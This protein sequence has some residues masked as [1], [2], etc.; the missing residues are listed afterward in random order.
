MLFRIFLLLTF[1]F[2]GVSIAAWWNSPYLIERV[3]RSE[4]AAN[5]F[6]VPSFVMDRP[7]S[8][9]IE[10]DS[11][12]LVSQDMEIELS[13]VVIKPFDTG[14]PHISVAAKRARIESI[15]RQ[16]DSETSPDWQSL[17]ESINTS[18]GLLPRY[19]AVEQLQ[20]C[21]EE[22]LA[23]TLR[24]NR[25]DTLIDA[26]FHIPDQN[27]FAAFL[28]SRQKSSIS[29]TGYS[30]H[31]FM[32]QVEFVTGEEE[33]MIHGD[34]RYLSQTGPLNIDGE[35][36]LNYQ[37]EME[38]FSATLKGAIPLDG[39]VSIEAIKQQ[40]D[41]T[42]SISGEPYW[43]VDTGEIRLSSKRPVAM[44]IRIQ[45]G[46]LT[47][48][49]TEAL[50]IKLVTPFLEQSILTLS[51]GTGCS[52]EENIGCSAALASLSS[53]KDSYAVAA[54]FTALQF[55]QE[56][57]SWRLLGTAEVNLAEGDEALLS[58]MMELELDNSNM[59]AKVK[60]VNVLGLQ[61]EDAEIKHNLVTGKGR[62][63]IRLM[64]AAADTQEIINYLQI[65]DLSASNGELSLE[66]DLV[67]K[68]RSGEMKIELVSLIS[69]TELDVAYG[70]Y[71]LLAG[72]INMRLAGWPRLKSTQPVKMSWR[73]FDMGVPIEDI[74]M[75][76]DL[77][78]DPKTN[79]ISLTGRSLDAAVFNGHVSSS[80]FAYELVSRSG[81]ANLTLVQLKLD[82]ILALQEEDFQSTGKISGSVPVQ[83]NQ[84]KLNVSKGKIS[85][86]DPGGFI[87]YSPSQAVA[88]L[89]AQ[90]EQ[91][92]VVVDTMSDFQ[93]HS[94][95]A[96]LE[97]SPEGN[98]VARTALK[99]SNPSFENGREIHL[100][101]KVE[102]NLATLLKSLRLSDE[103]SGKLGE[104]AKSGVR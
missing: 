70:E 37:L 86:I 40:L 10:I 28:W 99:G 101:L 92:K 6:D 73:E 75:A 49:L 32:G 38:S 54:S 50:D 20:W 104:K 31:L 21:L 19:G 3:L 7:H 57:E 48:L 90:N 59:V 53:V 16:Q 4:L 79:E 30:D 102:E 98:L 60:S 69:A 52:I 84:G 8:W 96:E 18:T 64:S 72:E 14:S 46:V 35:F 76:F 56:G 45:Q 58:S 82:Q 83:V 81:Y 11:I 100:N 5:G 15:S 44:D 23:G 63:R 43:Q 34:G 87:R 33:I 36:P 25:S 9:L 27:M 74:N 68:V 12:F 55:N 65:P 17:I 97:Y 29:M 2:L 24:W 67:W 66:A 80:D 88:N 89:V 51:S 95:D 41:A 91:L 13:N 42:L 71:Q 61:S 85:A 77:V 93:Y 78:L 1:S 94:L 26:Q 62:G 39:T 103:L 47:P 22:C